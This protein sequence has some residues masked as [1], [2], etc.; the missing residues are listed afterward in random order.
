MESYIHTLYN[1][2]YSF[3]GCLPIS[4]RILPFYE[5]YKPLHIVLWFNEYCILNLRLFLS[6][7]FIFLFFY[8]FFFLFELHI[9]LKRVL[10]SAMNSFCTCRRYTVANSRFLHLLLQVYNSK[11]SRNTQFMIIFVEWQVHIK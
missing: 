3:S 4:I 7:L 1:I 2:N 6:F 10:C 9:L 8:S 5:F 11:W